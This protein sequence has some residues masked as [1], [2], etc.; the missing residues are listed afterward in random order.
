M[1]IVDDHKDEPMIEKGLV[2]RI[3]PDDPKSPKQEYKLV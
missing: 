2:A 1:L 3:Y